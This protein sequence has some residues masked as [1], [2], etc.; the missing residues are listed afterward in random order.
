MHIQSKPIT[1]RREAYDFL[2]FF[3]SCLLSFLVWPLLPTRY[4]CRHLLFHLITLNDT[5]T[6]SRPP[7]DEGSARR[8]DLYLTIHNTLKRHTSMWPA[9]FEPTII[10]SDRPQIHA[11]DR[12]AA[13]IGC[14]IFFMTCKF[15]FW[16][17]LT[18]CRINQEVHDL[19]IRT[20]L[21]TIIS[22]RRQLAR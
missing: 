20:N 3:L 6:L 14:M 2:S 22:K 1:F 19:L 17:F 4:R 12:T 5:H 13:R 11:L 18:S 15:N 21:A 7:L 16:Y 8:R 10:V 9:G